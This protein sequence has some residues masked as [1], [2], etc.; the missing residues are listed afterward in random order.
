LNFVDSKLNIKHTA[1]SAFLYASNCPSSLMIERKSTKIKNMQKMPDFF[2]K[3]LKLDQFG[4]S[5]AFSTQYE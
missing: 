1:R 3:R 2:F 4:K 5:R